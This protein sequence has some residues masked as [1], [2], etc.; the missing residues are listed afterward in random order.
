MGALDAKHVEL[1]LDVA[2]DEI[3]AGHCSEAARQNEP[4]LLEGKT[5]LS[6]G[7]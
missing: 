5:G 6:V 3:S 1:A 4:R 2:E 7:H